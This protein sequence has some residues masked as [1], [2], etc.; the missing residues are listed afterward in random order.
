MT[1]FMFLERNTLHL[2]RDQILHLHAVAVFDDLGDPLPVAVQVIALVT[3]NADRPGCLDQRRQL[4][5]FFLC[6]RRLQVLRIDLVQR[7]ELAAARG[8][9]AVLRRAQ[10]AQ[11]QVRNAALVEPGGEL[12][13]GKAGPARGGD[14][15]HV[16]QQLHSRALEFVEHSL[17]GGLFIADGEE[18]SACHVSVQALGMS[19]AQGY[20]SPGMIS[21]TARI[22][23]TRYWSAG[24]RP[25]SSWI[26]TAVYF[27]RSIS[28]MAPAGARTLPS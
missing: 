25:A 28:S 21:I 8:V 14:G 15:A 23:A 3:E 4:V 22:M 16:H 10:P 17:G 24:S 2:R 6:L 20:V 11:M 19:S 1:A 12:V 5:E 7:I 18:L 26:E 9:A 13:L 27:T